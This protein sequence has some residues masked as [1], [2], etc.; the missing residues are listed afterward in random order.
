M[1]WDPTFQ[2]GVPI[3]GGELQGQ[4]LLFKHLRL[5]REG[6]FLLLSNKNEDDMEGHMEGE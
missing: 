5:E 3:T 6:E 4:D 1:G 2:A